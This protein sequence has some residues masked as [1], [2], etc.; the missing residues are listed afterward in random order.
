M[1]ETIC[2]FFARTAQQHATRPA[3]A[4]KR[5][6]AWKTWTWAE[7]HAQ[8]IR[9]ARALIHLGVGPGHGVVIMGFNRPEWFWAD[10]GA[11]HAGAVPAGIYSTMTPEQ[12]QYIAH[13]CEAAVAVVENERYLEIFERL[14]PQ[15]PHLKAI[16]AME[17][18]ASRGDVHA[19]DDFLRLGDAVPESV[20]RERTD[21]LVPEQL[22]TL[23]YTSG[24][25]G[26]PKAVMLSHR[27]ITFLASAVVPHFGLTSSDR[28]I[29]YLPLSHIAEQCVSLFMPTAVGGCTYFAESLEALP[30]NLR[31]VRPTVFFGVP[32]VWEKIQARMQAVGAQAP[33]LRRKIAAWARVRGLAGGYAQQSGGR[34]PFGYGLAKKLVFDKVRERLGFDHARICLTSA[35]PIS[36][37]TLEYFLSLGIPI[38]EVYGMSEVTGPTTLST[39]TRY[40]TGRAG[41]AFPGTDLRTAEDGEILMR[42]DHVFLGYLKDEAATRETVDAEGWVHSGDVGDIDADGFVKVTDRK[43]ELLIT[44]G[45][46]NVAPAPVEARLKTIPGVAQAVLLGDKKSYCAAL[47]TLDPERVSSVAAAAGSP[48][49]TVAEARTCPVFRTYL[50]GQIDA[51]NATLARY[52]SVR[53]FD[54]LPGEMTIEGGELTPTMKLKRRVIHAKYEAEIEALYS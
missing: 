16:V 43:K 42:G 36:L 21:A 29:S 22:C 1:A 8:V 54:V 47:L 9:T 7:H 6:G 5:E 24:T 19:W 13:H 31:E 26:A 37:G 20:V 35:A 32:R 4:V 49:R 28:F 46:K 51:M 44:S 2:Q 14:R 25:T 33:P 30:D 18:V 11:V 53:K 3:L 17:G 27:N 23:I 45:G 40:R 10:L 50:Q 41:F 34:L 38:L 39:P 48:A 12:V 52:E 15:L